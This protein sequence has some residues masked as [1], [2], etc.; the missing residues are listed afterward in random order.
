MGLSPTQSEAEK[1][2]RQN[3][4]SLNGIIELQHKRKHRATTQ[5][6]L[7]R[8]AAGKRNNRWVCSEAEG[9]AA[10][11]RGP[12]KPALGALPRRQLLEVLPHPKLSNQT[13]KGQQALKPG[14]DH[15]VCGGGHTD[16]LIYTRQTPVQPEWTSLRADTEGIWALSVKN[17]AL[18]VV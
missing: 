3:V 11:S 13:L 4:C 15:Q 10:P 17:P 9:E 6:L 16:Q 2:F 18:R 14:T 8:K 5:P 12:F 7:G 1:I